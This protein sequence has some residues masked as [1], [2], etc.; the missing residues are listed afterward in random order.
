MSI[1]N[2][3]LQAAIKHLSSI[4]SGYLEGFQDPELS[5]SLWA[6]N[7]IVL[8]DDAKPPP[9]S[10]Q[11]LKNIE[12]YHEAID[13]DLLAFYSALDDLRQIIDS[14]DAVATAYHS[15]GK[16]AAADELGRQL[17]VELS[18]NYLQFRCPRLYHFMRG[19]G[20]IEEKLNTH[21]YLAPE[22]DPEAPEAAVSRA[23]LWHRIVAFF[24][25]VGGY[26]EDTFKDP[27]NQLQTEADARQLAH[28]IFPVV[29]AAIE[30]PEQRYR[31]LGLLPHYR[32]NAD[33]D[34]ETPQL[35]AICD[36]T[37]SL[38]IPMPNLGDADAVNRLEDTALFA[39]AVF[40]P[41]D[42][43]GPGLLLSLGGQSETDIPITLPLSN[44]S[45]G[46]GQVEPTTEWLLKLALAAPATGMVFI[47][48]GSNTD[49]DLVSFGAAAELK[50]T[51]EPQGEFTKRLL[52]GSDSS[53]LELGKPQI[54]L[55][56]RKLA[57]TNDVLFDLK[58][59][60][61]NS[62][63]VLVPGEGDSFIQGVLPAGDLGISMDLGLGVRKPEGGDWGVYLIG[64]D[65]LE[66]TLPGGGRKLGPAELT[67][68]GA[69]L[70]PQST[71][72]SDSTASALR[73][74]SLP[75]TPLDTPSD[76][77]V[78]DGFELEVT[79]T[80]A[81]KLGPITATLDQMGFTVSLYA[82][83]DGNLNL[84]DAE[85]GYKAPQGVGIV[86][87]TSTLSGGG[88]LEFDP[89][90]EQYAGVVQLKFES[91]T[92]TAIGLLTTRLPDG[93]K[94]FSLLLIITADDFPAINLGLGF[95][96]TGVGG[97][98]GVNRTVAV[99]VL[100]EGLKGKTLDRV[101][102]PSDPL[103]NA[104]IIVST[105]RNV[106]PPSPDQYVLGPIAQ[107]SWGKDGLITAN[108]GLILEFPNPV[109]LLLLGQLRTC[110]PS[111]ETR[112]ITLN[113]DCLGILDIDRGEAMVLATLFDSKL[114][115][116]PLTGD[117]AFLVRWQHDPL[118][119]LAVGGVHPAFPAPAE[120]PP[121]DR[122][123]LVISQDNRV[124]LRLACY[125]AVTANTLQH[126][127][128][129][130]LH[131]S[132]AQVSLD[133]HCSYDVLIQFDPFGFVASISASVGLKWQGRTLAAVHLA[134]TLA[135]PSPWY[136]QGKATFKI[137]R[138]SKSVE[139]DYTQGEATTLPPMPVVDPK[140]QLLAALADLNN[141]QTTLPPQA[142]QLVVLRSQPGAA[143]VKVHPLGDIAVRQQVVPLQVTIEQLG[144]APVAPAQTFAITRATIQ[145]S[146]QDRGNSRP[147]EPISAYF[148]PGQYIPLNQAE[149]LSRPSFESMPAGVKIAKATSLSYGDDSQRR[150]TPF[151][152]DTKLILAD[153][154][155]TTSADDYGPPADAWA[156]QVALAAARRH[157]QTKSGLNRFATQIEPQVQVQ[158]RQYVI[159]RR[160]DLTPLSPAEDLGV[161]WPR[162]AGA[163][164]STLAASLQ[165][166]QHQHRQ[167]S[168]D[169]Q[170]V[171]RD[172]GKELVT[173]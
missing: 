51:F 108:V 62:A 124:Q 75:L 76:D 130:D 52:G 103:S 9:V 10:A 88:Y 63:L 17:L 12:A 49:F 29:V 114:K 48:I 20:F 39:S 106:F 148:A 89:E 71:D 159:V 140:P 77:T 34:S 127:A 98:L 16:W 149:R 120:L 109:R 6:I 145:G 154:S 32:W 162:Q 134:G 57:H 170:V 25:D 91:L 138:F 135:G 125:L 113:L 112:F 107:L 131:L 137:W 78:Q 26:L 42:H 60:L 151:T 153:G 169:L 122:L 165:A 36:R 82:A 70:K 15:D 116:Y 74:P 86:L 50:A 30:V 27:F 141:W 41:R 146:P 104:A 69:K 158:P 80:I 66:V 53:R 79:A 161:G 139:F 18:L 133:G 164:L 14:I 45:D 110:V 163:G 8:P 90:K 142:E 28:L 96:L 102:F 5:K 171:P 115:T 44:D 143:P 95:K 118:F 128:R 136:V 33:P 47:P 126:G 61:Q 40:V 22:A 13:P 166:I 35:D 24:E 3:V 4:L 37:L 81:V 94:G 167:G 147:P 46:D 72:D 31:D 157:R 129:L 1:S 111:Q 59:V 65:S 85:V 73:S 92:L 117:G 38:L 132:A 2:N 23:L 156:H 150:T 173:R 54:A 121:L 101:L 58:L 93:T 160:H 100:Q 97:L 144:Q 19:L 105:V 11:T 152:Y 83:A 155:V 123:A 55:Y 87:D 172:E 56:F 67:E 64:G 7:G 84:L 119:I 168:E 21:Y 99:E 43:G 68:I